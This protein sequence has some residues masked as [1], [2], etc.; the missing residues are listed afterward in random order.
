MTGVAWEALADAVLYGKSESTARKVKGTLRRF[1][2]WCGKPVEQVTPRDV[3]AYLLERLR[4]RKEEARILLI[5]L[6]KLAE[7]VGNKQLADHCRERRRSIRVRESE[8]RRGY[9]DEGEMA[10]VVETLRSMVRRGGKEARVGLLFLLMLETGI[11]LGEALKLRASSLVGDSTIVVEGKGGKVIYKLVA[12]PE[13]WEGLRRLAQAAGDAPLFRMSPQSARAWF[14]AVLRRAGLPEQRVR[15]LR[16]HDLRRTAAVLAYRDTR[17]L[18]AVR[19]FLGH[20][21]PRTTVIYLGEGILALEREKV[22]EISE[23]L[24]RRVRGLGRGGVPANPR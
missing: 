7:Y 20:S 12:D 19:V 6:G 22:R 23:A 14:K 8:R 16:P 10:A 9:L 11:R 24:A 3:D 13:V 18:D 5:Y 1:F 2:S 4:D 15:L 21:N 17:D